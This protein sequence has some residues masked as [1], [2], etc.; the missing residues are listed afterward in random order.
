MLT[1]RKT[2]AEPGWLAVGR[3]AERFD[4]V[5]VRRMPDRLPKVLLAESIGREKQ[6]ATLL[7]ELR[8]ALKLSAYRITVL[9]EPLQ[10]QFIQMETPA[11]MNTA[12]AREIA[13]WKL[14]DQVDF[15]VADAAIDLLPIP[16]LG[17]AP[18]AYAVLA[19]AAAMTPLVQSFQAAKLR[20]A[21]VDVPELSQRNLAALF[22]EDDRGL[23]MLI[24]DDR[25]GL[26]TFNFA[27]E[28]LVARHIEI[29]ATQLREAGD[30]RR[31]QLFERI[32]LDVQ[33]SL[34]NFDRGF[35]MVQISALI[36]AEIP[37]VPGFIDY[38]RDNLSVAVVTLD[39]PAVLDF[40]AAPALLDPQR[41]FQCLRV[42]G[43]ALR[44]EPEAAAA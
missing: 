19:P 10:Y 27:G 44:D 31:G 3:C 14:K 18:Q 21:A 20:L 22:E 5:H 13:R 39:L 24:F 30:E 17:R 36:I 7:A 8:R 34:D 2:S 1:F 6:D 15:P 28:L 35:S 37:G 12:E 29:S 26:L 11:E 32:A 40:G 4:L 33:R 25:E 9:L 38:L 43:A 42:L 16:P 41:R 23:A